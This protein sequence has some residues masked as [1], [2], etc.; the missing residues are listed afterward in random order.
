MKPN[1]LILFAAMAMLTLS[2]CS[3]TKSTSPTES[4]APAVV[5]NRPCAVNY[6]QKGTIWTSREFRTFE[7]FPSVPQ[8]QAFELLASEFVSKGMTVSQLN[9]ELGIITA[10][11]S[12][13]FG[14]GETVPVNLLVKKLPSGGSRIEMVFLVGMG[15]MVM[16]S[17]REEFC[18]LVDPI[19]EL[20]NQTATTASKAGSRKK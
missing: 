6:T 1:T 19:R 12:V 18:K 20:Q 3:T 13:R 7:E 2:S 9:K 11:P 8:G 4:T 16:K 17:P 15:M 14:D 10:S 5:D